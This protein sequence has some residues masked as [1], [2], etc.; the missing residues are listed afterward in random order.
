VTQGDGLVGDMSRMGQVSAY[1]L[2]R[3]LEEALRGARLVLELGIDESRYDLI[4]Q[5]VEDLAEQWYAPAE[6]RKLYAGLYAAYLVFT[7]VFRYVSGTFWSDVHPNLTGPGQDAGR[8]FWRALRALRLETFDELV[9]S[10]HAMPWVTRILAHGGIPKSCLEPFLELVTKEVAVGA[11][12]ATELLA[13]WRVNNARLS[14]LHQPTRRFLLYGGRPSVDLL[15]RCIE[16]IRERKRDGSVPSAQEAGLP[17]YLLDE[18]ARLPAA[19]HRAAAPGRATFAVPRP[20]VRLDPYSGL[21]P[22]IVLPT[23]SGDLAGGTWRVDDGA[24]LARHSAS[25]LM[26]TSVRLSPARAYS[27]EFISN[28]GDRRQFTF[29]ALGRLPV[30]LLD[31]DSER[32]LRDPSVLA[33]DDVWVL[34]P[35]GLELRG[36]ARS[37]GEP[38]E[39]RE[40]QQLPSPAGTWAGWSLRHLDLESVAA[41]EFARDGRPAGHIPVTR[42]RDR[43][44]LSG[45]LVG[46]VSTVEGWPV[47]AASPRI[48]IRA[49]AGI[50]NA[51]WQI[52]VSREGEQ[53]SWTVTGDGDVSV[54]LGSALGGGVCVASLR[55]RG[56][57][58]YDLTE[59]LAVVPG[60]EVKRPG[61]VVRPEH[62]LVTISAR[63]ESCGLD[64]APAGE[65]CEKEVAPDGNFALLTAR[66]PGGPP[67]E[68]RVGVARLLWAVVH[69][70]KP[71]VHAAAEII[72]IGAEE[73][74]DQLADLL[75]VSTGVPGSELELELRASGK[76]LRGVGPVGAAGR[77]G[78]WSFDLGPFTD[79]IRRSS[80]G[81]FEFWLRV[82]GW[83]VHAAD[84]LARIQVSHLC[85]QTRISGDFVEAVISFNQ[86]REIKG[87]IARL[88]SD[89]RPWDPPLE[90]PIPD[91][92]RAARFAG[93]ELLA[94]G[95]YLAEVAIADTWVRPGRP[96]AGGPTAR[97]VAVGSVEEIAEHLD[98]LDPS[99]PLAH[100]TWALSGHAEPAALSP[101]ELLPVAPEIASAAAFVLLD[102]PC[103]SSSPA[104]FMRVA[105]LLCSSDQLL[106][107]G[108]V[109]ASED[110]LVEA[111]SMARLT[112]RMLE[113]LDPTSEELD[114]AQ[115][116]AL[117][118]ASPPIAA[119]L[120][121]PWAGHDEGAAARC[122]THLGWENPLEASVDGG[123]VRQ[124]EV[125]LPASV[126][127]G[128]R[129]TIGLQPAGLLDPAELQSATFEWLLVQARLPEG[130]AASPRSWYYRWRRLLRDP[131]PASIS[132]QLEAHLGARLPP[133][134]TFEWAALPAVT[135]MA[136]THLATGTTYAGLSVRALDEALTFAPRLVIHDL[137]LAVVLLERARH[138]DA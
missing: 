25:A 98:R 124:A 27:V 106:C 45:P 115:P 20:T 97:T 63:A 47:Y 55:V 17:Q 94:P 96:R 30:L 116:S 41:L 28:D 51:S 26:D 92:E 38:I 90:A 46:G 100:V 31:P 6:L 78:R 7:G 88:W 60:L 123:Q 13:S 135:L 24:Q 72:R 53:I 12:D 84:V 49:I 65:W 61:H 16:V 44:A 79:A 87:R 10:E 118:R 128:V 64:S 21:G 57:L 67:L 35:P 102:T 69:E 133:A 130:D 126:L 2:N 58:G 66:P 86:E 39:L 105:D 15:D 56:P 14:G 110:E 68:F 93:Y 23:V 122:Q 52:R 80:E 134:G 34:S 22:T 19:R 71:A 81:R 108:L 62:G 121:V 77:E 91:G 33:A 85:A 8:E 137:V 70:G 125:A 99:D 119:R 18:I 48:E 113:R 131:V 136:A 120:D 43:P 11:P 54:D 104:A 36:R 1:A 107:A 3:D 114:P 129:R 132:G 111:D 40:V 9:E 76:R 75:V 138:A 5:S 4:A 82:N 74:D 127:E 117:W 42:P 103:D 32:L 101:Q 37:A 73:F 95:P 109:E 112:L 59:Q 29:E 83:P 50:E 89:Y